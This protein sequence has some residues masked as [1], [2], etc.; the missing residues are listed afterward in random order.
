MHC[1]P[2]K[3]LCLYCEFQT[4]CFA[5]QNQKQTQLPVK[6]KKVK[7]RKR[8]F[9]YMVFV[10][11]NEIFLKERGKKDIWQGLHDFHLIE[12]DNENIELEK[13]LTEDQ[14]SASELLNESS[15]FKHIL[16]HQRITAKFYV[17]NVLNQKPFV[18]ILS[19]MKAY[20]R[21][22]VLDVP[23]PKLIDNYLNEVF[24]SLAL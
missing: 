18:N 17:I 8:H 24:F 2:A 6:I 22:A 5:F 23:I 16:T 3:P 10:L 9:H 19:E 11:H 13:S 20:D 15:E 7:V 14:I 12:S 21:D 4:E 1:T